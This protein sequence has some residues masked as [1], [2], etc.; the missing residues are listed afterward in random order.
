MSNDELIECE[1]DR[2]SELLNPIT[3]VFSGADGGRAFV[4][5]RHGVLKSIIEKENPTATEA[6]AK[7]CI[8][9]FSNLCQAALD[10]K[11]SL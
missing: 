1:N 4:T 3:D 7:R 6:D 9:V 10:G 8:E 11:F 5:L 2:T